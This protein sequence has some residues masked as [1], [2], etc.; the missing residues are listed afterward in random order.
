MF[1]PET[2]KKNQGSFEDFFFV[3]KFDSNIFLVLDQYMLK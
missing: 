1:M 3:E 2:K